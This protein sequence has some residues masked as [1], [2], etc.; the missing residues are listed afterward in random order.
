MPPRTTTWEGAPARVV[1]AARSPVV[2]GPDLGVQAVAEVCRRSA[3]SRRRTPVRGR[4][5]RSAGRRRARRTTWRGG[6]SLPTPSGG[7][8]PRSPT[9]APVGQAGRSRINRVL[10]PVSQPPGCPK[11]SVRVKPGRRRPAVVQHDGMEAVELAPV[12]RIVSPDCAAR[13]GRGRGRRAPGRRPCTRCRGT[14]GSG[15][16]SRSGRAWAG[17]RPSSRAGSRF[18]IA[19]GRG[20]GASSGRKSRPS[21]C[22]WATCASVAQL[23]AQSVFRTRWWSTRRAGSSA[24]RSGR[25]AGCGSTRRTGCA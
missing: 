24:G 10:T 4:R 20:W 21:V 7:S 1:A 14:S 11:Q 22:G 16:R 18:A 19:R 5:G 3:A 13:R 9:S 15:C 12:G 8:R 23:G 2:A 25:P 6:S 17:F